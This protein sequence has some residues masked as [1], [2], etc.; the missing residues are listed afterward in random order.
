[1]LQMAWQVSMF[2]DELEVM[3]VFGI[4]P[5]ISAGEEAIVQL[6][7]YPKW[8]HLMPLEDIFYPPTTETLVQNIL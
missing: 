8:A 5:L 4:N 6:G 2:I 3:T 7:I 1:M